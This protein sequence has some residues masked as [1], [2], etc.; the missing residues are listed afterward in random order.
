MNGVIGYTE[1]ALKSD[2]P[3]EMRE[4]LEKI[5]LSGE[6]L[7]MLINDTLDLSRMPRKGYIAKRDVLADPIY[8]SKLVTKLINKIM[9]DGKR[10][11]AQAILYNAFDIIEQK[12][13][14]QPMAVFEKALGNVMPGDNVE[15]EVELLAPIAVEQGT[16]FSIREG[17]RTVGSGNITAIEK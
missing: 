9:I 1:L 12:T 3:Q 17:G 7:L 2:D 10:G 11:T 4:Y 5:R 6:T 16:K 13:G 14:E 15:M 8:N